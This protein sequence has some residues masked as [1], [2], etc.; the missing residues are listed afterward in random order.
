MPRAKGTGA[1]ELSPV[2]ITHFNPKAQKVVT[3]GPP[4]IQCV[5]QRSISVLNTVTAWWGKIWDLQCHPKLGGPTVFPALKV[6]LT[7]TIPKTVR[8]VLLW[9]RGQNVQIL[10]PN[11]LLGSIWARVKGIRTELKAATRGVPGVFGH[12]GVCTWDLETAMVR[13]T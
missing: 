7:A 1:V 4:V 10:H 2:W 3:T 6:A 9:S 12:H 5:A 8:T 13:I 11:A